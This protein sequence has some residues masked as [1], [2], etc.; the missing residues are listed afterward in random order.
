MKYIS[1][2]RGINVGGKRKIVMKDLVK[3]YENLGFTSVKTYI[4]SGNVLFDAVETPKA[5]DVEDAI[6]K[7][8]GFDVPVIISTENDW[9][10]T[11]ASNPFLSDEI[12]PKQLHVTFL[13]SVPKEEIVQQISTLDYSPDSFTIKDKVVYLKCENPYHKT[14]LSNAFFEKKLNQKATTRNWKTVNKIGELLNE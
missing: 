13:D 2:L 5:S 9:L 11:I 1:I 7:N 6:K 14:K 4:Q 8:Y 12:D 10:K 3:L